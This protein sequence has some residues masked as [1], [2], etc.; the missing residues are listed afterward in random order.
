MYLESKA[1][2][3]PTEKSINEEKENDNQLYYALQDTIRHSKQSQIRIN[4]IL[5]IV[6]TL[7]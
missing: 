3:L 5:I 4:F 2:D 6:M 7:S 1:L